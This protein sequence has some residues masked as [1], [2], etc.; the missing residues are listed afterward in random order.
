MGLTLKKY[1]ISLQLVLD[2]LLECSESQDTLLPIILCLKLGRKEGHDAMNW[3][4]IGQ[5][6]H[7]ARSLRHSNEVIRANG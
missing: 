4:T 3:S 6:G 1:K 7:L 5:S 2:G